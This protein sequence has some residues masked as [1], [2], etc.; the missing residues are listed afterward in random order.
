M[1]NVPKLEKPYAEFDE[2][3]EKGA[4]K[5]FHN[6]NEVRQTIDAVTD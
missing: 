6:F 3:T 5:K 1:N 2:V 4:R